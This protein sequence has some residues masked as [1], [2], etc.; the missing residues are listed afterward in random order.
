MDVHGR[1][2]PGRQRGIHEHQ[3][4]KA[5]VQWIWKDLVKVTRQKTLLSW[6]TVLYQV[7]V[8]ILLL[9][10]IATLPKFSLWRIVKL[11][12]GLNNG[13]LQIQLQPGKG[14]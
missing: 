10:D 11:C 7:N 2:N 12:N 6:F 8:L 3:H 14:K 13:S 1:G 4:M 9:T 5:R